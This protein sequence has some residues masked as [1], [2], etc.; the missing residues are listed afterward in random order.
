MM[1]DY[2]QS[3]LISETNACEHDMIMYLGQLVA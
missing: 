3:L 1:N 2:L